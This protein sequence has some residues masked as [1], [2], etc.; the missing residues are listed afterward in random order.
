MGALHLALNPG[1][2]AKGQVNVAEAL[3]G[4]KVLVGGI[5]GSEPLHQPGA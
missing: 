2:T 1:L 4:K 3:Q 5:E